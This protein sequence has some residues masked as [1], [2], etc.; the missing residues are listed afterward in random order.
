MALVKQEKNVDSII[1]KIQ[2]NLLIAIDCRLATEVY[3]GILVFLARNIK[4]YPQTQTRR[5]API[6]AALISQINAVL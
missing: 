6:W 1:A 4:Q 2:P 5:T 3:G